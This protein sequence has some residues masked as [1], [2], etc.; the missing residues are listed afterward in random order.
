[1]CDISNLKYAE[2]HSH[3]SMSDG[4]SNIQTNVMTAAAL[5]LEGLAITDHGT[6]SGLPDHTKFCNENGITP[7][8]GLEGYLYLPDSWN[9]LGASENSRS[10]RYHITFLTTNMM[11]YQRLIALNNLSHQNVITDRNKK[12]PM[13]TFDM[14]EEVAG[15]GLIVL[16]G[17]VS[18]AT[19]HSNVQ[20]AYEYVNTLTRIVGKNNLYAEIMPHVITRG[21]FSLNGFE[22]PL[23]L[24]NKFGLKTVYTTDTHAATPEHLGLLRMYSLAM[25]GYEFT[26]SNLDSKENNFALAK[27]LIGEEEAY[28]AFEGID[29][30]VRKVEK[31]NFK[32]DFNLPAADKEV[33][34]MKAALM[35]AFQN[36]LVESVGKKTATGEAMTVESLTARLAQETELLEKYAFFPY[37]AI[38]WDFLRVGHEQDVMTVARGSASGSYILFLLGVTQLHPVEHGLMFERFLAELRLTRN[39]FPDVDID[40]PGSMRYIIQE[41]ARDRWGFMPV[42]TIS[43]HRHS[44]AVRAIERIYSK[45]TDIELPKKLV[46]EASDLSGNDD[47]EDGHVVESDAFKKFI[48]IEKWMR[49]MYESLIGNVKGFGAH[50]CAVVPL[51]PEMPVPMEDWGNK[52]AVVMYSQSGSNNTLADMGLVKYDLLSSDNLDRLL[53]LYKLT[54]V[55]APKVVPDGDPCFTVFENLQSTGL[56]QFDTRVSRSL[57]KLMQDNGRKIDSIRI[58]SDLTSLGRPGPLQEKYHISYADGS[59]MQRMEEHPEIVRSVFEQTQGVIIYQEQVAELFARVAF[60]EYDTQAK[61]YGIVALKSLVPKNAKLAET[62]KFKKGYKQMHDM[63]VEGGMNHHNLPIEYL[64]ELFG[65]LAGFVRYGFNLSHSL[66]YANISA[67][68]AWYKYYYPQAFWMAMLEGVANDAKDRGKL[69]RYIVDATLNSG[70]RFT[71]PNINTA[72][73]GYTLGDDGKTIQCPISMMR[74]LGPGGVE[75]VISNQPFTSLKDINERTSLNKTVKRT[76]YDAGM[77]DGLPGTLHDLGVLESKTFKYKEDDKA[78]EGTVDAIE[79]DGNEWVITID[80]V[81]YR[82]VAEHNAEDAKRWKKE[83]IS[84]ITADSS[85]VNHLKQ[86]VH[87]L[88]RHENGVILSCKRRGY[89]EPEPTKVE[90]TMAIKK[91]LGFVI[92]EHLIKYFNYSKDRQ[93]KSVGYVVDMEIRDTK[94]TKQYKITL[95]D[96]HRYWFCIEDRTKDGFL[97]KQS[98]IK[99]FDEVSHLSIGDLVGLTLAMAKKDGEIMTFGQIKSF[100]ILA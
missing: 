21:D 71:P 43:T 24:A 18:S 40:I 9:E 89:T 37:F 78:T 79:S 12:Y 52:G 63:F 27:S 82:I 91:A 5:G 49:P 17:C 98:D 57:L 42:G 55:K 15:D 20:V 88:F 92:P 4:H 90:D 54:G 76:M 2:L 44:S 62:E 29:E 51:D 93:D 64:E 58:L 33:V 56:F 35:S 16:T 47:D 87:I 77:L 60:K 66:S 38:M 22:R 61:E 96:G 26:A 10:G 46:D 94:K 99:S 50:A 84:L 41:Y 6:C 74:G 53:R 67:Q 25:S 81:K 34:E 48:S 28:K 31:V 8:L 100:K 75:T 97:M 1:M 69:M 70:L 23:H 73:L 7:I 32:R 65:S 59:A 86:G 3:S 80:G 13:M 39:E 36:D 14:L 30:I 11:G 19:F 45:M 72:N 68:E 85:S 95:Q 83:K